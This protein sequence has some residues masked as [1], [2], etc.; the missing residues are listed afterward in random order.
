MPDGKNSPGFSF[1]RFLACEFYKSLHLLLGHVNGGVA[2][3]Y[4]KPG[5]FIPV[6]SFGRYKDFPPKGFNELSTLAGASNF[7]ISSWLLFF[8]LSR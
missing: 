6:L 3:H 4:T 5:F 2:H 1:A 7:D 8:L